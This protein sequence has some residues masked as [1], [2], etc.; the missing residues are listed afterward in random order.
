MIQ[1]LIKRPL[2]TDHFSVD[3]TLIEAWASMKSFKPKDG[4]KPPVDASGRN[5]ETDFHGQKRSNDTHASTTDPQARLYRKRPAK[6]VG[7][8]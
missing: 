4:D 3:G 8:R 1:P 5:R 7:M 6:E 2:G